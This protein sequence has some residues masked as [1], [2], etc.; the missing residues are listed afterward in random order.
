MV[1]EPSKFED[2]L[3]QKGFVTVNQ[4][5]QYLK[6]AHPKKS[7]S[8]PTI[9]RYIGKG[10]FK[11]TRVGGQLRVE[12]PEI[13]WFVKHGTDG[14]ERAR[15]LSLSPPYDLREADSPSKPEPLDSVPE[16]KDPHNA[17]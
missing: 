8:F 16:I 17:K 4:L 7:V 6:L 14:I 2:F 1:D 13:V 10:Y 5:V 12:P 3:N 15:E 9:M 11:C